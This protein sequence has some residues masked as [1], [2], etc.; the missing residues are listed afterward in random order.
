MQGE[1]TRWYRDGEVLQMPV[2]LVDIKLTNAVWLATNTNKEK[3]AHNAARS[4]GPVTHGWARW[5][6]VASLCKAWAAKCAS[7]PLCL[8]RPGG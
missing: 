1:F 2:E 4:K 7:D 3:K 5:I 8:C 6:S